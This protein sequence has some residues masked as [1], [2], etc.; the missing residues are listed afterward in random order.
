MIYGGPSY[1]MARCERRPI[2]SRSDVSSGEWLDFP[3][4]RKAEAPGAFDHGVA[5][6]VQFAGHAVPRLT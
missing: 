1:G 6:D 3:Q 4:G 5:T 2:G